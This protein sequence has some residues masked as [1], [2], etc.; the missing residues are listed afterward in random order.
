MERRE[1][2]I[3]RWMKGDEVLLK[4]SQTGLTVVVRGF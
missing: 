2:F 1:I 3:S 4:C